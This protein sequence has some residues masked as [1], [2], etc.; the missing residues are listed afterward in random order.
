M[1]AIRFA[2]NGVPVEVTGQPPTRTLLDWLREDRGLKG[3]KEGCNEGDCGA[4]TVMLSDTRGTRA[5]NACILFLPQVHGKSVHTVEGLRG[6]HPV[7]QAMVAEH[8]SQCGFCTPGFVMSMATGH[9]NGVTDHDTHLAGNLC[10]CT[11]YAPIVRAAEAAA[12]VPVPGWLTAETQTLP[13]A[14]AP[15]G[16]VLP[17]SSDA[18]AAWY[19]ANPDGRLVAGATDV[20][21]WVTKQ[22]RDLGP[23]AFLAGV[24]DMR[25]IEV[26]DDAIHIGAVTTIAELLP[27]IEPH[28]PGFAAM[29]RRYGSAQ[30]REAATIGGNIANGSPIGD[31]PPAL[32]ALGAT[33]YLRKGDARRS[34]PLEDFFLEYGK[35]D[36]APGEFVEAVSIPRQPDRLKCYKIS[37]R[38]DQ[39][40]SALLGCFNIIVDQGRVRAARIAFGGMAG[41]PKRA[42][43]VEAALTG[44]PWTEAS[45]QAA[46]PAFAQDFTPL[47]DMRASA[48]YRLETAQNLLLRCFLEDQ[49]LATNVLE[50]SA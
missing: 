21:L 9:L 33:L 41:I 4:C 34:M 49:G 32:I 50:V 44:K 13:E 11:G 19:S 42:A 45:V 36:R 6:E 43:A 31:S 35:Q 39:D 10:R 40:I 12:K 17:R 38:F 48:A 3:T 27:A 18:L 24:D 7:Q 26:T 15:E 30:V 25:G 5:V 20:G 29:L 23:V 46:L 16:V 37:K 14:G 8:G 47:S 2:L 28:H 1:T 22:L